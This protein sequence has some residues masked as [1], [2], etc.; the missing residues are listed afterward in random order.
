MR[1]Q[2]VENG[3]VCCFAMSQCTG[4][5]SNYASRCHSA[6]EVVLIMLRGHSALEVVLI[7]FRD[8]TVHWK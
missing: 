7:M 8:V 3:S 6:L 1:L 5:S 4:S 2:C